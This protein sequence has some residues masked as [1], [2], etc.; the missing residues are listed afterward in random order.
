MCPRPICKSY[1]AQKL[2]DGSC[3]PS[4]ET[5]TF[6]LCFMIK[7]VYRLFK[8]SVPPVVSEALKRPP[9]TPQESNLDFRGERV[10]NNWTMWRFQ[11]QKKETPTIRN[12]SRTKLTR[13]CLV[14]YN[15]A[16]VFFCST[17]TTG[18]II[19]SLICLLCLN[20]IFLRLNVSW[21]TLREP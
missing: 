5:D 8:L 10:K 21:K 3:K 2:I 13:P 11:G 7:T 12:I 15:I 18:T 14:S 9:P 6:A 17:T 4:V 16:I 1:L 19:I 20:S